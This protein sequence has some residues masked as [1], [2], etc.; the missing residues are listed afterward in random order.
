LATYFANIK[1]EKEEGCYLKELRLKSAPS[2]VKK[3]EEG[4]SKKKKNF[5]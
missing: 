4:K 2:V 5:C 1:K 3:Q